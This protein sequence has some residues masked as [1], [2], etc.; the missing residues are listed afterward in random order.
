MDTNDKKIT[1]HKIDCSPSYIINNISIS[2]DNLYFIHNSQSL[3]R[4]LVINKKLLKEDNNK[5]ATVLN[6]SE[7]NE[8]LFVKSIIIKNV[9]YIAIGL[10][11]GFKLWNNEG[12][13]LLFQIS[14]ST[15]DKHKIYAFI[16][17]SEFA[18]SSENRMNK[19]TD[20]ILSGDN[21]GQL[22]LISGSKSN[23]KS[24]KIY[25]SESNISILS[26]GSCNSTNIF[27]I[28]L[29]NGNILIMKI[30]EKGCNL[31]KKFDGDSQKIAVNSLIFSNKEKN[32]YFLCCGL[33]NGELLI[34]SLNSF[35]LR[36]SINSNLRSIG[37]M[38]VY[39]ESEIIVASEDGQINIWAYDNIK[40]NIFLKNNLL[41]EDQM[42]VGLGF[43]EDEQ[44]LYLNSYDF[45]HIISISM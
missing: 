29:E 33:I 23:W 10:Y 3:P 40:K 14:N 34:Y 22:F 6:S 26:I 27:G 44:I 35:D 12:N 25:K 18:F 41:F 11:N 38:I 37:P 32:E 21:Y 19:I 13:R 5:C 1:I 39:N 30:D 2:K 45:P 9:E 28:T 8:M 43:D 4:I 15:P 31:I 7:T 17:C 20:C 42:I 24:N 36:F 16:C